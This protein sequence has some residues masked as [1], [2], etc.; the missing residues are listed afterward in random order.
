MIPSLH[1][2]KWPNVFK[3]IIHYKNLRYCVQNSK[4]SQIVKHLVN[5]QN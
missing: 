5:L 1:F 4:L 3:G 2:P